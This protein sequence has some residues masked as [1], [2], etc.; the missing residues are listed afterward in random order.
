MVKRKTTIFCGSGSHQSIFSCELSIGG[1]KQTDEC[2]A[3][4]ITVF[5]GLFAVNRTVNQIVLDCL[6]VIYGKFYSRYC[7]TCIIKGNGI[8]GIVENKIEVALSCGR[9]R[10]APP[11]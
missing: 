7:L 11:L 3:E 4:R 9:H 10:Q 8:L 5:S 6:T 1:L 2:A